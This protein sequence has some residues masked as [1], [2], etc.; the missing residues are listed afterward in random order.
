M[1]PLAFVDGGTVNASPNRFGATVNTALVIEKLPTTTGNIYT[2]G[3]STDISVT[4]S[5]TPAADA[6]IWAVEGGQHGIRYTRNANTGFIAVPGVTVNAPTPT[7]TIDTQPA[8]SSTLA[9]DSITG[10]LTVAASVSPSGTPN[11]QWYSNS[12]ESN[13]NG[14]I[15]D[16]QTD[17]TFAIPT[18]LTPGV[19]YYYVVVSATEATS[20]SSNVATVFVNNPINNQAQFPPATYSFNDAIMHANTPPNGLAT[21]VN[22]YYLSFSP[23]INV[24]ASLSTNIHFLQINTGFTLTVNGGISGS[25]RGQSNTSSIIFGPAAT[26]SS[27]V[28]NFYTAD[29]TTQITLSDPGEYQDYTFTWQTDRWVRNSSINGSSFQLNSASLFDLDDADD[30]ISKNDNENEPIVSGSEPAGIDLEP[31]PA[32]VAN[33]LSV[34]DTEGVQS[35]LGVIENNLTTIEKDEPVPPVI[36]DKKPDEEPDKKPEEEPDDSQPV[37]DS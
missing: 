3:T 19:Y 26:L 32:G 9:Q 28:N 25:F 36:P 10:S 29:G 24:G 21:L 31:E 1:K 15:I 13:N 17:A 22:N 4:A 30:E 18:D 14:T 5:T 23:T 35:N 8:A 6:A 12:S 16:G 20:V 33:D 37:D 27:P 7:I 11:Y 34:T 2:A